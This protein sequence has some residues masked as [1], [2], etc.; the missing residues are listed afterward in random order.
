MSYSTAHEMKS[1]WLGSG[2]CVQS[3]QRA[4]SLAYKFCCPREMEDIIADGHH[5]Q[6]ALL[7]FKIGETF[8]STIIG[9][10][11]ACDMNKICIFKTRRDI[12]SIKGLRQSGRNGEKL[13]SIQQQYVVP[14]WV[15]HTMTHMLHGH[16]TIQA[17]GRLKKVNLA[18]S[19]LSDGYT[20]SISPQ[21]RL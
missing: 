13:Q 11:V 1:E 16:D 19:T 3:R 2:F 15:N 9:K 20:G 4:E 12:I 6:T 18:N 21:P 14:L 5:S 17:P 8:W 7:D 10:W